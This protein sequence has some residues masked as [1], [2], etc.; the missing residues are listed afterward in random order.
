M[1]PPK[2]SQQPNKKGPADKGKTSAYAALEGEGRAE[3]DD[4]EEES[5][6]RQD[7]RGAAS[8][9]IE[10]LEGPV[11]DRRDHQVRED[12]RQTEKPGHPEAIDQPLRCGQ[13]ERRDRRGRRRD[14]KTHE[15]PLVRDMGLDV[16]ARQ[17]HRAADHEEKRS[18]PAQAE[19]IGEPPGVGEDRRRHS[20]GDEIGQRVVFRAEFRR[21]VGHARDPT[22]QPGKTR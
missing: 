17:P 14:R 6:Q 3:G 10:V 9:Q 16:E 18:E 4:R 15:I 2:A 22:R 19:E 7:P 20:E 21:R 1:S 8:L 13:D 12:D 5:G 11:A